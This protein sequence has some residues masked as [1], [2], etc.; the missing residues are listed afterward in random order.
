MNDKY[1]ADTNILV[2][3]F[4]NRDPVKQKVAQNLLETICLV[5]ICKIIN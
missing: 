4:D 5:K 1:F 3:A 2:Y